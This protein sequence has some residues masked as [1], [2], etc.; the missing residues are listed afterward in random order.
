VPIKKSSRTLST[1]SK[2]GGIRSKKLGQ[3]LA[4]RRSELGLSRVD[5]ANALGVHWT[6]IYQW[7]R[8]LR[9]I[10]NFYLN[11]W[12]EVLKCDS[13]ELK[14]MAVS[15]E[16][17]VARIIILKRQDSEFLDFLLELGKAPNSS[18]AVK[19]SCKFLYSFLLMKALKRQGL[20]PHL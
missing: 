9:L 3:F 2:E 12:A 14:A 13:A 19:E 15:E 1:L 20:N 6:P 8:A 18:R 7:E 5:I 16:D 10:S 11:A 17:T 4:K